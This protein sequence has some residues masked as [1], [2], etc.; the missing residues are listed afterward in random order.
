MHT[1]RIFRHCQYRAIYAALISRG[2][3]FKID[4]TALNYLWVYLNDVAWL[5]NGGHS[6]ELLVSGWRIRPQEIQIIGDLLV[7][8]CIHVF[9]EL[10][11]ALF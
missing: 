2:V 4:W 7:H 1:L 8:L 3:A 6:C 9:N 11:C 5:N 10:V